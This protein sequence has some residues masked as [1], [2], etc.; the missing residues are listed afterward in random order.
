MLMAKYTP[1]LHK[2]SHDDQPDE[3]LSHIY[4]VRKIQEDFSRNPVGSKRT[5]F[6]KCC[7]E[8]IYISKE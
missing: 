3:E 1:K 7:G 5:Q 4:M 8:Q 2:A 6:C